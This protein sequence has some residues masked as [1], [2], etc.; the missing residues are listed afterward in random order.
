MR[1]QYKILA[2]QYNQVQD[3]A[4]R[5]NLVGMQKFA[6]SE[7]IKKKYIDASEAFWAAASN[8]EVAAKDATALF[9][10]LE[11]TVTNN[12]NDDYGEVLEGSNYE[13][14]NTCLHN[15]SENVGDYFH[16]NLISPA[17]L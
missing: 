2:E 10:D 7:A 17:N 15:H 13:F 6:N 3:E 9:E 12:E 16:N 8:L 11:Q 14:Y 1:N 4:T 5:K